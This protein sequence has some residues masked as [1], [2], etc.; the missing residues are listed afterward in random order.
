MRWTSFVLLCLYHVGRLAATEDV[1]PPARVP[2]IYSTDLLHPHDDPDD[3]YDLATL[4]SL[5]E[6]D[7]RGIV[8]D[9][10]E[11]QQQRMG[12]P[13][14][15]QILQIAGR[16][17]PYAIGVHRQLN[18][19]DDKAADVPPECQGGIE[20]I[21]STLRQSQEKVVIF[22]T[23]S[24]RDV[25]AACNREPELLRDKVRALYFN[26][27]NGPGGP[28]NEWN[29]TLDPTAYQRVFES[30]LPLYW[31]PCFGKD[32]YQTYFI[33]D[34]T[35]VVGACTP[36]VQNFFVYCLSKSQEDPLAFLRSGSHPLPKGPR[37]MW[38]TG[39]LYHA[40]GRRIYERG[41]EDFV[42]LTAAQAQQAGL[43]DKEVAAFQFAPVRVT[44]AEPRRPES[45]KLT[46]PAAG[47]LTA[48]LLG[49]DADRVGTRDLA[50][51]GKPDCHVRL[52]GLNADQ[53]LQNVVLTG[54]KEGRWEHV[55]TG[56]WWRV[57][58]ERQGRQLDVYF[59]F[60]AA[61]EH[62]A[63][64]VYEDK[65]TQA[66]TFV[67]PEQ[68]PAELRT[69]LDTQQP[70][71]FLFQQ[72]EPRFGPILASCLKNTLAEL[73]ARELP[74]PKCAQEDKKAGNRS[75]KML[76]RGVHPAD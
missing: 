59:Q 10:G 14:V 52:L 53:P 49:T 3:H 37:N 19:R 72:T 24:L 60:W 46:E 66:A 12:R 39:P 23:G 30:G 65:R 44:A 2:V 41:K 47:Q 7:V 29:V 1:N 34:Q 64:I 50:P 69:E 21:L 70:N 13:P 16:R 57:A 58:C 28:Q 45:A 25:A 26:A 15:E 51:D 42:A 76:A 43:A 20:L 22:T 67:I 48:A 18:A 27:G 17:V 32:G 54:P 6:L 74:T 56:R 63:E 62:R 4:F 40:A 55:E 33:A 68:T 61:G 75:T 9:L 8:L 38:C 11:R 35:A 31:C 71:C 5:P 36:V 73:G